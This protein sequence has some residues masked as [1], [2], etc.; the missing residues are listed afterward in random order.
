MAFLHCLVVPVALVSMT[1]KNLFF[2]VNRIMH[3]FGCQKRLL[4]IGQVVSLYRIY[5]DLILFRESVLR[6]MGIMFVVLRTILLYTW[7]NL[8]IA[9]ILN[10]NR[11][12]GKSVLSERRDKTLAFWHDRMTPR[13]PQASKA[14]WELLCQRRT[15]RRI[16]PVRAIKSSR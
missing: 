14:H 8:I 10:K 5:K 12:L 4:K 15:T 9:K 6:S 7:I 13:T 16:L 2:M 1:L 3:I 11:A